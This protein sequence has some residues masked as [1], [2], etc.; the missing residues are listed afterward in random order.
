MTELITAAAIEHMNGNGSSAK[1]GGANSPRTAAPSVF[2]RN[3]ENKHGGVAAIIVISFK[4][5]SILGRQ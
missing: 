4:P 3:F 2:V 5:A 1:V